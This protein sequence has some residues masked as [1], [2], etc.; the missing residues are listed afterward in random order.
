[1]RRGAVP[2]K[3]VLVCDSPGCENGGERYNVE[4]GGRR[5]AVILCT[6]HSAP[7]REVAKWGELVT[8]ERHDAPQRGTDPKRLRT[9]IVDD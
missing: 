4:I 1:M 9:L 2:E 3:V 8:P 7:V 6:T 5:Y